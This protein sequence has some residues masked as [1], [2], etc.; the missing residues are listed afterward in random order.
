MI[1][2]IIACGK[3]NEPSNPNDQ[4]TDTLIVI[5]I[6]GNSYQAVQIGNQ[7]W[8][9]ENLKTTHFRDGTPIALVTSN[10]VW[11]S[12]S[13]D[14]YSYYNNSQINKITYGNLY[15]WEAITSGHNLAP[16]G[17][18]VPSDSEFQVLVNYLGGD[19]LAGGKMK[20]T[21]TVCWLDPN[22]GA[23]NESGFSALPGGLRDYT[24]HCTNIAYHAYFWTTTSTDSVNALYRSL[25]YYDAEVSRDSYDKGAGMSVRCVRD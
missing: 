5:D 11:E 25:N 17:W 19:S 4:Q 20:T 7:R 6:N 10:V 13:T 14:G 24:G 8:M 12:L 21:G 23:T 3:D 2:L 9:A 15:K 22:D 1:C 18:H 16:S